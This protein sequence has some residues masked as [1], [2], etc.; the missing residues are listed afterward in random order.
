MDV[1]LKRVFK[2]RVW[3]FWLAGLLALAPAAIGYIGCGAQPNGALTA[4]ET[5][6]LLFW[7]YTLERP[8]HLLWPDLSFPAFWHE[9]VR[10]EFFWKTVI[11]YFTGNY[12]AWWLVLFMLT[13]GFNILGAIITFWRLQR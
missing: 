11:Q 2:P 4:E 7:K 12:I 8:G 3:S 9:H 13:C 5:K 6:A 1:D 10:A